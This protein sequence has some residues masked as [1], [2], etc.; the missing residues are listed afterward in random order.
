MIGVPA[1]PDTTRTASSSS[2]IR[3]QHGTAGAV[4]LGEN[5]GMAYRIT[6]EAVL[7]EASRMDSAERWRAWLE[8]GGDSHPVRTL[9]ETHAGGTTPTVYCRHCW[10]LFTVVG[11]AMNRPQALEQR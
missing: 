10:T 5:A 6:A 2:E 7:I 3:V 11:G 4:T 9:P 1:G 8:C